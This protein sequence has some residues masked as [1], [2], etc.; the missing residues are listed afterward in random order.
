[1]GKVQN[2]LKGCSDSLLDWAR[3]RRRNRFKEINELSNEIKK[4]QNTEGPHNSK[5]IKR[6]QKEMGTLLELEDLKWRQR[7]KCNWYKLE[8]K[9]TKFFHACASQRNKKNSIK[10][11]VDSDQLESV[12]PI[13]EA[14]QKHYKHVFSSTNPSTVELAT[15][16]Q[17]MLPRVTN[18]TNGKLLKEFTREEVKIALSQIGSL[19]APSPDGFRSCV[20]QTY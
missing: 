1:M 11:M 8:E 14:F 19:K 15:C 12:D 18:E 10:S 13:V 6:L 16:L 2:L 3:Y 17:V 9:N 4:M 7:A 20:C 5:R